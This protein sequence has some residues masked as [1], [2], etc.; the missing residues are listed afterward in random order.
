MVERELIQKIKV[1]NE[2]GKDILMASKV[3]S[4]IADAETRK[5][6]E[7]QLFAMMDEFNRETDSLIKELG[8]L[9]DKEKGTKVRNIQLVR[10]YRLLTSGKITR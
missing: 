10:A 6:Y 2:A 7:T 1:L 4:K 3:V 5:I 8:V 9:L